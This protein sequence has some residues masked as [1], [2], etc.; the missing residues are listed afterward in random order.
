MGN[1]NARGSI[2]MSSAR[3]PLACVAVPQI[4]APTQPSKAGSGSEV[5][6]HD[7]QPNSAP[8]ISRFA[9]ARPVALPFRSYQNGTL[10]TS[11]FEP[12]ASTPNKIHATTNSTKRLS[13]TSAIFVP[14]K[15][16]AGNTDAGH[17]AVG[18]SAIGNYP[19]DVPTLEKLK[20]LLT[21][22]KSHQHHRVMSLN[23]LTHGSE[24]ALTTPSDHSVYTAITS[25][26]YPVPSEGPKVVRTFT[27]RA[28]KDQKD[29]II[30]HAYVNH[31]VVRLEE[32]RDASGH[33]ELRD[34]GTYARE[35]YN[36]Q[37]AISQ[38][39]VKQRVAFWTGNWV[40]IVL[41]IGQISASSNNCA[42]TAKDIEDDLL[43]KQVG[44][45]Q[46]MNSLGSEFAAHT[47]TI[48]IAIHC[49]PESSYGENSY[50]NSCT[51][52]QQESAG[53]RAIQNVANKL[54]GFTSLARL[55]IVLCTKAHSPT[56]VSLE[57][58]NYA[59]PFYELPFTHW[60][61]KW[62]NTYMRRPEPI[63]GWPITYLDIERGRMDLDI[64]RTLREKERDFE[65][66]ESVR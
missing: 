1:K 49:P 30:T 60:Q 43:K 64:A 59:L 50:T 21:P 33:S 56:P 20:G 40:E 42:P 35:N 25:P 15:S 17:T 34:T 63:R 55:E 51:K 6:A 24:T 53:Y 18:S 46:V 19:L 12:S 44:A 8:R 57:Q 22:P 47:R 37:V 31:N 27:T 9:E 36:F 61:L 41:D 14:S 13:A 26:T 28:N 11:N 66:K 32:L 23:T 5:S 62:Q 3:V 45:V 4:M 10:K 54:K 48:F 38:K 7:L 2:A 58:L 39:T 29:V 16:T 65:Q 52:E